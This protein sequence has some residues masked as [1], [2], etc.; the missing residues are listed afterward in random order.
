MTFTYDKTDISTDLAK[1]RLHL[2]DTVEAAAKWS[3]EELAF[4]Q[5]EAGSVHAAVLLAIRNLMIDMAQPD[6]KADWL[7]ES[8]HAEAFKSLQSLYKELQAQFGVNS[9]TISTPQVYGA[10]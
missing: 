5:T 8:D 4:F 3:D 2:R 7:E 10:S 6:Y 1:M 9:F